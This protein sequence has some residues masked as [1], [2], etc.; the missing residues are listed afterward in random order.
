[1]LHFN[2][3]KLNKYITGALDRPR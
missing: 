2:S 1:L 3:I